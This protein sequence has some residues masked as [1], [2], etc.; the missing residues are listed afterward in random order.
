M[1][2]RSTILIKDNQSNNEDNSINDPLPQVGQETN[3]LQEIDDSFANKD[4]TISKCLPLMSSTLAIENPVVE[5]VN[6][7]KVYDRFLII[8]LNNLKNFIQNEQYDFDFH[9]IYG[10]QIKL[11]LK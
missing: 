1:F 10:I 8:K 11:I 2:Y 6:N 9:E 7:Q 5:N 4:I 3:Y